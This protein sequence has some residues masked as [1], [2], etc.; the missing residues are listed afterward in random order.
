L[1]REHHSANLFIGAK[2]AQQAAE[3]VA[4]RHRSGGRA[5]YAIYNVVGVTPADITLAPLIAAR[6]L[7]PSRRSGFGTWALAAQA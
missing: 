6:T 5:A 3:A 1:S 4:A 7:H 2:A